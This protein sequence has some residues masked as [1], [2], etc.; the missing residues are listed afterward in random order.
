MNHLQGLLDYLKIN[1]QANEIAVETWLRLIGFHEYY[2]QFIAN[3]YDNLGV[4]PNLVDKDLE[5]LGV[6]RE[7]RRKILMHN[8]KLKTNH[9]EVV[10]HLMK[11]LMCMSSEKLA[12]EE[13]KVEALIAMSKAMDKDPTSSPGSRRPSISPVPTYCRYAPNYSCTAT[14]CSLTCLHCNKGYCGA[15]MYG[16]GGK[17]KSI[18]VCS[19]CGKGPRTLPPRP[20]SDSGRP[21]R[22]APLMKRSKTLSVPDVSEP[23]SSESSSSDLRDLLKR[24]G[25]KPSTTSSLPGEVRQRRRSIS[26]YGSAVSLEVSP[27]APMNVYRRMSLGDPSEVVDFLSTDPRDF[28]SVDA[29][30]RR[31]STSDSTM[32]GANRT[33]RRMSTPNIEEISL[34]VPASRSSSST[35]S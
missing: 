13:E 15:C 1:A 26:G 19:S 3:G 17:M 2:E 21:P 8:S 20:K 30:P 10:E 9:P 27:P 31:M 35:S 28:L 29:R 14:S 12:K 32:A 33:A 22:L 16:E 5:L 23:S 4:F 6:K 11:E 34:S 7:H 18:S 24:Y 25:D